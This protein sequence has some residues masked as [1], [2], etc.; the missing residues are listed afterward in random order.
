MKRRLTEK[1]RQDDIDA[2]NALKIVAGYNPSNA[3]YNLA[4]ATA[5]Y[6]SMQSKQAIATQT[7]TVADGAK[8][9]AIDGE[10]AFHEIILG[11]KTQV[12][13]QYGEDSNEY[14]SLG[15][16]KKSERKKPATRVSKKPLPHG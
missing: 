9:D 4:A 6:Q 1:A 5:A 13:A 16:V 7:Q 3:A 12:K 15:L 14:Q 2:Y 11:A 10:Q 8:D